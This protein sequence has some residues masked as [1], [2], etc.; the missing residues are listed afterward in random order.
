MVNSLKGLMRFRTPGTFQNPKMTTAIAMITYRTTIWSPFG[1]IELE[2]GPAVADAVGGARGGLVGVAIVGDH[3]RS[4]RCKYKEEK[5][6]KAPLEGR[7]R[8]YI[9]L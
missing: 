7:H 8:L 1:A 5:G 9:V 3:R 2:L 6:E 4:R